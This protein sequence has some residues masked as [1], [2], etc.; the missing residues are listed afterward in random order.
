M[1]ARAAAEQP[2]VDPGHFHERKG[3]VDPRRQHDEVG[4]RWQLPGETEDGG[5]GVEDDRHV[6]GDEAGSRGAD[7]LL[8]LDCLRDPGVEPDNGRF[9]QDCAPVH[10]GDAALVLQDLEVGT[11]RDLG[12]TEVRRE[13]RGACVAVLE[14]ESQIAARRP[15]ANTCRPYQRIRMQSERS[16]L[17]MVTVAT[18]PSGRRPIP[19][20]RPRQPR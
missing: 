6:V 13:I 14:Y 18:T 10:S 3:D 7:A 9:R 5:A 17:R 15:D 12:D 8:R 16:R 20:R 19:C 11:D 4:D 2:Y 1:R